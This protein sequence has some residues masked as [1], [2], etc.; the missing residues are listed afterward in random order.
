MV[1]YGCVAK[2]TGRSPNPQQ[3]QKR[4]PRQQKQASDS[5]QCT[6]QEPWSLDPDCPV[7]GKQSST[8]TERQRHRHL[9]TLDL[10]EDSDWED[11]Q[12]AYKKLI[13]KHHPDRH[14]PSRRKRQEGRVKKINA[15]YTWLKKHC[16]EAA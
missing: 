5:P 14:P 1:C 13:K 7:H 9:R 11:I 15:A 6:C 8:E 10:D 2:L 12:F 3:E 4:P 16:K